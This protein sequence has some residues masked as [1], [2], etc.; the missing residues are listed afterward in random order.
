MPAPSDVVRTL[1]EG[2]AAERFSELAELYAEQ[3]DVTHPFIANSKALQS[4]AEV[5]EHFAAMATAQA[6][7]P[8]REVVDL[9]IHQTSDPELVVAEYAYR[10]NLPVPITVGCVLVTRVRAGE[11]VESRDYVDASAAA[12]VAEQ[13][14]DA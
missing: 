11:I 4:R 10:W 3:T 13:M 2:V 1:I 7:L 14:R 6:R 12:Q 5:R 8:A 9:V